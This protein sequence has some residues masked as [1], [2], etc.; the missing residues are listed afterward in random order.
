LPAERLI[1][2]Q[3]NNDPAISS[4]HRRYHLWLDP[5][6]TQILESFFSYD[7]LNLFHINLL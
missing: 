4:N 3:L 2:Q 6:G 5:D 7:S 1:L